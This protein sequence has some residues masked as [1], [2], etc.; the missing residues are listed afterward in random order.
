M[1]TEEY[2]PTITPIIK[3]NINPLIDSPPKIKK[4]IKPKVIYFFIGSSHLKPKKNRR[5]RAVCDGRPLH[6]RP[7]RR[8]HVAAV[9]PP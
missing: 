1:N 7:D 6:A 2:V 9:R 4:A 3:A 8:G 5:R